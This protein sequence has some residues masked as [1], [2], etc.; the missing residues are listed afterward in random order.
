M[1]IVLT[2]TLSDL[3][4]LSWLPALER[5]DLDRR[6]L[7]F[8]L[9]VTSATVLVFGLVPA[10]VASRT[11]VLGALGRSTRSVAGPPRLRNALVAA[12]IALSLTL[13]AGAGVLNR[14]QQLLF[15]TDL[16]LDAGHVFELSLRP[17]YIGYDRA[18]ATHIVSDTFDALKREGFRNVAISYPG[19]LWDECRNDR[20]ADGWRDGV[21]AKDG[22]RKLD[23]A[24]GTSI[25]SR[26]RWCP[27]G[28]S[29]RPSSASRFPQPRCPSS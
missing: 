3:R 2:T 4:L 13:V 22:R 24:G 8:S 18:K 21:H 6:V 7:A 17:E 12:Q 29:A 26:S 27:D 11:N 9:F 1:A 19:P 20:R 16:G 10:F 28:R 23:H 15:S 25:C 5:V 14:L